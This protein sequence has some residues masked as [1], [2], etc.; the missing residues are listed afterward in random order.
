MGAD[1]NIDDEVTNDAVNIIRYFHE[2]D[3]FKNYKIYI[4]GHS[5]GA[6]MGPRIAVNAG[7]N[8]S[9]MVMLAGNARPLE[10]LILEQFAYINSL[11]STTELT[12]W[13]NSVKK[14]VHYL[15]SPQFNLTSPT[16]SLPLNLNAAYWNSLKNYD[17]LKTI[18]KVKIP[19]LILQGEKDYQVLMTDFNLWKKETKKNKN[20]TLKSYPMLSHIFMESKGIPGP[21]DYQLKQNIPTIVIQDIAS[22]ITNNSLK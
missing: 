22:W 12:T 13:Y 9:G 8:L 16:D 7:K 1:F 19:V 2:N 10:V 18:S 4:I 3:T 14:Q 11:S 5:L 21:D 15:N 17:Q 6:M 20:I